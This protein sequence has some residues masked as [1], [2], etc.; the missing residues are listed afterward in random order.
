MDPATRERPGSAGGPSPVSRLQGALLVAAGGVVGA[1]A[2]TAVVTLL[3]HSP[4]AWDWATL[5]E[6]T[7]GA[8]LLVA[9]LARRPPDRVRLLFGTG[10]LGGFTTF[11]GLAL[12]VVLLLDAGRLAVAAAYV[13]ASV[14]TLLAGGL[15]GR[16]L[17]ALAWR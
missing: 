14:L 15:L 5:I 17:G 4:A 13:A 3:P 16:R 11:S 12:G 10:V 2:R 6:N 8:G 9:L 7:L 1:L